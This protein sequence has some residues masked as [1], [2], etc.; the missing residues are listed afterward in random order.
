MR[1]ERV[2]VRG[3]L[4]AALLLA[5][6]PAA[7]QVRIAEPPADRGG[8]GVLEVAL[9]LTEITVGDRLE[10]QLT[11]VWTGAT[12]AATPRFPSWQQS[13]GEAEVLSAGEVETYSDQTARQIYRQTVVL[14]AFTT[15]EIRLPRVSVALPLGAETIEISHDDEARFM[16]L[17]VLPE[18]TAEPE[19]R[20]AAPPRALA[21]ATSFAWTTGALAGTGLLMVWLLGR[22][23]GSGIAAGLPAPLPA[24][25]L[26]ELLERLRRLDPSAAE[27]AHTG[28]S[29][30]LRKFL[31]RS[32]DF[33]AAESTTSEIRDRLRATRVAPADAGDAVRLL[34]DC[35]QVKFARVPVDGSVTRG[36]LVGARDLAREIDRRL[37]PPE[38]SAEPSVEAP[39]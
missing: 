2:R 12:P 19:P 16:V 35:D 5:A 26:A 38:P 4:A 34:R 10:A 6:L 7:A 9:S 31:G 28:L 37:A 27:P 23:L 18:G 30:A 14:T 20:P 22:R 11:L 36:R 39:G 29:L 15:G 8:T 25:P 32:L 21:G 1:G 13:W 17:S 24:E 3:F 33:P